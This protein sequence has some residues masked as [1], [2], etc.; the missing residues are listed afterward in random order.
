M[1]KTKIYRPSIVAKVTWAY[2]DLYRK[3]CSQKFYSEQYYAIDLPYNI[4]RAFIDEKIPYSLWKKCKHNIA[5]SK[6]KQ[7]FDLS[8]GTDAQR[9]IISIEIVQ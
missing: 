5:L 2:S 9:T 6:V 3:N 1:S 4:M 7:N 8:V